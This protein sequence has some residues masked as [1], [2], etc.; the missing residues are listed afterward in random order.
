MA[1]NFGGRISLDELQIRICCTIP[2]S[3]MPEQRCYFVVTIFTD[4]EFAVG[5]T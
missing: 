3:R 4:F 1:Y 2:S 5:F